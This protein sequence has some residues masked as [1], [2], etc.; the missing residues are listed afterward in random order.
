MDHGHMSLDETTLALGRRL[1]AELKRIREKK[2]LSVEAVHASTKAPK[3]VIEQFEES[4]LLGHEMF[5]RVYLRSFARSYALA[6]NL[7]V[8]DVLEA[9]D[10]VF[11]GTYSGRLAMKYLGEKTPAPSEA[12]GPSENAGAES[13]SEVD[14]RTKSPKESAR[15][16]TPT[17]GARAGEGKKAKAEASA[18]G[19]KK[20]DAKQS[21]AAEPSLRREATARTVRTG[22]GTYRRRGGALRSGDSGG[23]PVWGIVMGAGIV[24]IVVVA[25]LWFLTRPEPTPEVPPAPLPD[26]TAVEAPPAPEPILLGDTMHVYVVA[27]GGPLERLQVTVDDDLRRPFWIEEGDSVLFRPTERIVFENPRA[28]RRVRIMLEGYPFAVAPQDRTSVVITRARAQAFLDSL[29]QTR[30][31]S[32]IDRP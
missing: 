28:L 21:G 6:L 25:V 17:K 26:T 5:N 2:K 14:E 24:L 31:L 11:A 23:G 7:S 16:S 1:G 18:P 32:T 12:P 10:E 15:K 9:L 19:K 13:G 3:G 20:K 4:A 22:R 30:S 29:A 27:E 8:E